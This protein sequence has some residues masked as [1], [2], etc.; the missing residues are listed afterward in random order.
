MR[1]DLYVMLLAVWN[2]VSI[3]FEVAFDPDEPPVYV[4]INQICDIS[5]AIDIILNFRTTFLNKYGVE[6]ID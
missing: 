1:W 4:L 2:C 3:P 5:F 6:E